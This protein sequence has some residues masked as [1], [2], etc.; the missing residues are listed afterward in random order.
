MFVLGRPSD[1][2]LAR[3]LAGVAGAGLTYPEVGATR[4]GDLPAGY[5][6]VRATATIGT[7]DADFAAAADGVRTWRLHRGQGFR[8]APAD[9]PL[10]PGTEVVVDAPLPGGVH[11]VAACRVV[12][13]VDEPDRCGF[14]YGTLPVHPETGEEAFVVDRRPTGEVTVTVTAFSR[15]RH[16]LAR[17]GGP[18]ARAQQR[19]ATAGYVAALRHHVELS[20]D[21]G[22]SGG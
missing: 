2:R 19:R 10:A 4:G 14:A 1:D 17:L 18:V 8:V 13:V 20:R 21:R 7:G 12:W 3:I 22:P 6:H 9:P 16:W 15:A 11:V 5:H